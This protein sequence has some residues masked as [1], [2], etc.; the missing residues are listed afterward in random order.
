MEDNHILQKV[1]ESLTGGHPHN[2]LLCFG[3]CADDME[4]VMFLMDLEFD[5][6][7]ITFGSDG[8][9]TIHADGYA[10]HMFSIAQLQM[11]TRAAKK[12]ARIWADLIAAEQMAS[13]ENGKDL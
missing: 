8:E 11:I 5:P 1:A 12:A 2:K 13:P 7:R 4:M 10:Y 9:V 6:V 3:S